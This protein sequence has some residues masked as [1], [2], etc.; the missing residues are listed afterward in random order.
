VLRPGLLLNFGDGIIAVLPRL[1]FLRG[2]Q[3]LEM[4]R[5]D[6]LAAA[7]GEFEEVSLEV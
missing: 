1:A 5:A 4:S 2:N 6:A 3:A 7:S